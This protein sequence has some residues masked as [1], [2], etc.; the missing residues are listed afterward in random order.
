[1]SGPTAQFSHYV[2]ANRSLVLIL[3][4][5]P[6]IC[7]VLLWY[8]SMRSSARLRS[9]TRAAGHRPACD[10]RA[11]LKRPRPPDAGV[12]RRSYSRTNGRD[13]SPHGNQQ[14]GQVRDWRCKSLACRRARGH[15][16][17]RSTVVPTRSRPRIPCHSPGHVSTSP[18]DGPHTGEI[19]RSEGDDSSYGLIGDQNTTCPTRSA[20][21]SRADT[22]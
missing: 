21:R 6:M 16:T 13:S 2:V 5:K 22:A 8:T 4:K 12:S 18:S 17:G 11:S 7:S 1:M 20:T 15:W 19:Q 10:N 3:S 14:G 9:R